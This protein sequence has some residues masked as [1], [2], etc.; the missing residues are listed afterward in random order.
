MRYFNS[1]TV[2]LIILYKAS[3]RIL[4]VILTTYVQEKF[5]QMVADEVVGCQDAQGNLE[6]LVETKRSRLD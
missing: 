2:L 1:N 5:V 6:I 3:H 4:Y